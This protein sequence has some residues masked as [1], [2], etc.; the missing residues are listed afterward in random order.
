MAKKVK[1]DPITQGRQAVQFFTNLKDACNALD[2]LVD[3]NL[4][5]A[6]KNLQKL[7]EKENALLDSVSETKSY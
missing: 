2:K 3:Y 7:E 4:S 5:E 6:K 1:V